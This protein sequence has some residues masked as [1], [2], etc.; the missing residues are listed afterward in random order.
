MQASTERAGSVNDG[1]KKRRNFVFEFNAEVQKRYNCHD[2]NGESTDGGSP[3][4]W[5]VTGSNNRVL[6]KGQ[7][8]NYKIFFFVSILTENQVLLDGE[9]SVTQNQGNKAE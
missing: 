8:E 9:F 6:M 4:E 7:M 1:Y 3:R 2:P 5:L